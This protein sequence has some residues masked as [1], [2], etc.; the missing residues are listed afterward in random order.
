MINV[1]I[2]AL[3]RQIDSVFRTDHGNDHRKGGPIQA[4]GRQNLAKGL[5]DLRLCQVCCSHSLLPPDPGW[6]LALFGPIQGRVQLYNEAKRNATKLPG[7]T[8]AVF[9]GV[10]YDI[11]SKFLGRRK[12]S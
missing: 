6:Q 3:L 2:S 8:L 1:T 9:A 4:A 12:R 5:F 7:F 11:P 10:R